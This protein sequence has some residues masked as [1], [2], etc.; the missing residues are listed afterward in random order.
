[1]I[2]TIGTAVASKT[3]SVATPVSLSPWSTT[4]TPAAR[5]WAP[6]LV[7]IDG[8]PRSLNGLATSGGRVE[9]TAS[10]G[11]SPF[12]TFSVA[13]QECAKAKA[14]SGLNIVQ[15]GDACYDGKS[16]VVFDNSGVGSNASTDPWVSDFKPA[17]QPPGVQWE[18]GHY[19]VEGKTIYGLVCS[20]TTPGK[21]KTVIINHGGFELNE[22]SLNNF[23]I[24]SAQGGWVVA[25][26]A[27]RGE[28]IRRSSTIVAPDQPIVP[29]ASV[30]QSQGEIE[31]CLGEITDVLRL[32]EI[33][34][35]WPSVDPDRVLMWGHS[36]GACITVRAL[37]RG[38]KVKAAAAF[39]APTDM[40]AW[41]G[42]SPPST[43]S[44]TELTNNRLALSTTFGD[45][46]TTPRIRVTPD[47]SRIPYDWRSPVTYAEDLKART[48]VKI[49]LLQ[50][51]ED[52]LIHP[53]QACALAFA[54][55]PSNSPTG[56]ASMNWHLDA[57]GAAVAATPLD[58]T[59]FNGLTW[60]SGVP[61]R[62]TWPARRY[63]LV[64]DNLDHGSV[65]TG[66]AWGDFINWVG[67]IF[68]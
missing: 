25:M 42:Y 37:Q 22:I 62:G 48:D 63:L 14:S 8:T 1:M 58:C 59:G 43:P 3:P 28:K 27:Y 46:T 40:A 52:L 54:Y 53:S 47:Q 24:P 30:V 39:A 64:Y 26:S 49:L 23:C 57:S 38:V 60:Q 13:A 7:V 36:H 65:L 33:V 19:K 21:H 20:P 45:I 66:S 32:T 35:G 10:S 61:P 16:L 34:R 17:V 2:Q 31:L 15:A 51:I 55:A 11:G 41:Y 12:V 4:L 67:V 68:P 56:T 29:G 50:G 44:D 18:L 5:F 6:Q 9:I